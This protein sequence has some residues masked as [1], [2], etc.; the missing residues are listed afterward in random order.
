MSDA[1]LRRIEDYADARA[2]FDA[3]VYPG[4]IV[5]RSSGLSTAKAPVSEIVATVHRAG[6]PTVSR[7]PMDDLALDDSA[8]APWMLLPRP[9]RAAFDRLRAAGIPLAE[10]VIGRAHLGVKCGLNDAFLV[11]GIGAGH[12]RAE[13][14]A[15]DGRSGTIESSLLR[16][17][18]RGEDVAAWALPRHDRFILW[19]HD[20][21]GAPIANLPPLA[22]TW[23]A[24]W[25][26]GLMARTDARSTARWWSLFRTEAAR[27]NLPRVVWADLGRAP[28]AAV[29]LPHDPIVPLNSCYVAHCRDDDDAFAFAALLNSSVAAAWLNVL[30]EP[31]RGGYRRYL[32]WTM[33]LL[34]L[35]SDWECARVALAAIGRAASE[36]PKS[37]STCDLLEAVLIAYRVKHAQIAPLLIWNGS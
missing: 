8:G 14:V 23:F 22:A 32:G 17:V 5:A 33:S 13:I 20:P 12:G 31:A 9:V 7:I 34:P 28:R 2:A 4:L 26:R 27:S 37:V 11:R 16:P 3:S 15:T 10:S 36:A 24:R 25:R 6:A 35:P 29:L 18:A 30:A 19:T 21:S 1:E